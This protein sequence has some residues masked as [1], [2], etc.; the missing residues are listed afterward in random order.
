M[1]APPPFRRLNPWM[2]A[3]WA[4][5][6][7]CGTA[8]PAPPPT[9]ISATA[10][11]V[12]DAGS[13]TA[14]DAL[15]DEPAA[16]AEIADIPAETDTSLDLP[17]QDAAESVD[18]PQAAN[19]GGSLPDQ[20]TNGP[21][22]ADIG[23]LGADASAI[24]SVDTIDEFAQAADTVVVSDM[25]DDAAP[26]EVDA[27][28]IEDAADVDGASAEVSTDAAPP[29]DGKGISTTGKSPA[30]YLGGWALWPQALPTGFDLPLGKPQVIPGSAQYPHSS[31]ALIDDLT[32]DGIA[33]LVLWAQGGELRIVQ[34]PV[35]SSAKIWTIAAA[36]VADPRIHSVAVLERNGGHKWLLVGGI[37]AMRALRFSGSQWLDEGSK[38]GI[39]A[40]PATVE[41]RGLTVADVDNDGLLDVL[42]AQLDCKAPRH[43]VWLDRGDGKMLASGESLGL[44]A[45]GGQW[46]V[47]GADW[48][49]DGDLDLTWLHDGCADAATTQAFYRNL[50][51]GI[52]GF[53]L[54]QR[55][56]P[57]V[58]FEFPKAKMPFAS[59]M[60]L[61]S[62][63]W[64][65]DGKLDMAIANV[66]LG[67]PL[68]TA[69]KY[70]LTEDPT[71]PAIAQ[72]NLL[73]GL[74]DGNFVDVGQA[75]GLKS[76]VDA[77]KGHDMTAW[78]VGGLDF[79]RDGW[80]DMWLANASEQ[81]AFSDPAYG[82]MRPVV[83]RNKGD[84]TFAEVSG[85]VGIPTA[86]NAPVLALG[87]LDGDFDDDAV[88]GQLEGP[89]LVLRNQIQTTF[90]GLRVAPAGSLSNPTGRGATVL[91]QTGAVTQI[92][93]IG[94]DATFTTHH[95][96]VADFG[97][98][99]IPAGTVVV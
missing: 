55:Q 86:H 90:K 81:D 23:S 67:F 98:A 20:E 33:D 46:G 59:P 72:N 13:S 62:A 64:D 36:V 14:S 31:S 56:A 94:G 3:I 8:S 53:P 9:G 76:L 65:G 45:K 24:D 74:A 99:D 26:A 11:A 39:S 2:S 30:Q 52:D 44:T 6:M 57:N 41:R 58:L 19:D 91:M 95:P 97:M 88:L 63:D 34:G 96:P 32:G 21:E 66:G 82:P 84:G 18:E 61:D 37:A 25:A 48:D 54:F 73:R 89:P 85:Q 22:A 29:F 80:L 17:I 38:L 71:V 43:Q 40:L 15:S 7:A 42:V 16:A 5:L 49:S 75:A 77:T 68:E 83:M 35:A 92:R 28:K 70:L 4:F 51:R 12:A 60:G 50:G 78:G 87:D 93:A 27:G 79:D 47:A 69:M 1:N 10:Q